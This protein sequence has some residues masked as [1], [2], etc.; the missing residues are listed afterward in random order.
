MI[1]MIAFIE[2]HS[3]HRPMNETFSMIDFGFKI[4]QKLH[5]YL[6]NHQIL[7]HW[8]AFLNTIGV[9]FLLIYTIFVIGYWQRRPGIVIVEAFIFLFRLLCGLL[10]QLPYSNEYLSSEHDFPDCLTNQLGHSTK[11]LNQR[12]HSSFF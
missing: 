12:E 6:E 4:T 9:D 3:D 2:F 8:L 5:D 11:F 7:H 10:T 1:C